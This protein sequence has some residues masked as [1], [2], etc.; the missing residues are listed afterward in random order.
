MRAA[1]NAIALLNALL[2]LPVAPAAAQDEPRRIGSGQE[3]ADQWVP[4]L[5]I[6]GGVTIQGWQGAVES[7]ICR[8]CSFPD[9]ANT[10][11]LRMSATGGDR[12]VTPYVGGSLELMTPEL[13]IP[14]SPR[15]FLG[16][17][18]AA[19]FGFERKVALEGDPGTIG[20]PF[21]PGVTNQQFDA[22]V[23]TGQGSETVLQLDSPMYGVYAGVA[24]PLELFGRP[25]RLKPA[26]AWLRYDLK[27]TGLIVDVE[28]QNRDRNCNAN[29]PN[30]FLR[31]I[32]L[33][34][35]ENRTYDGIGP[36]LDIEMDTG[37]FGPLGTS[38]FL[39][40][41]AYRILGDVK[42]EFD[43][44]AQTFDDPVN[45]T[46]IPPRGADTAR[47]RFGFEVDP[48]MYRVGLGLRLQWLGSA[49]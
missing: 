40:A 2:A 22:S 31:E 27:A 19:T 6:I 10:E 39:G 47:A 45:Q 32:R 24:F 37:R 33:Q 38:I 36:G 34:G 46:A 35:S 3:G 25:L 49:D 23:A 9:P 26:F 13:P 4:S 8:G 29:L 44:P 21:P 48:W 43:A 5:S 1:V 11:P 7:E 12:D 16:G 41:R 18:V 28:C 42:A 14:T 20:S 17:E 30:S 15:L